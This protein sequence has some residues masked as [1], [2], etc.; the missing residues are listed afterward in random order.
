MKKH[1][2]IF[3]FFISTS[4][5]QKKK[6]RKKMKEVEASADLMNFSIALGFR[7]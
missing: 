5:Q 2:L 6:R 7:V 1:M 3:I 4:Q